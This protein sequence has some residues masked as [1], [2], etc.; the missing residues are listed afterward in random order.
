MK[1]LTS[2]NEVIQLM[3]IADKV[4]G[5]VISRYLF[6]T[7]TNELYRLIG[8]ELI[9]LMR[10]DLVDEW[11]ASTAYVAGDQVLFSGIGYIAL[12]SS[13]GSKP[14]LNPA[15]WTYCAQFHTQRFRD[16]W[17]A[18]LNLLMAAWVMRKALPFM[19]ATLAA[20]GVMVNSGENSQGAGISGGNRASDWFADIAKQAIGSINYYMQL[21]QAGVYNYTLY[22][23][24]VCSVSSVT[25]LGVTFD[26]SPPIGSLPYLW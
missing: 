12:Q 21:K 4:S 23:E 16:L 1:T 19:N 3:P 25:I 5:L 2:Y 18:G 11:D 7:E 6:Q 20:G 22:P 8:Q 15:D 13:T 14:T 26:E 17:D 10:A 24:L 9:E